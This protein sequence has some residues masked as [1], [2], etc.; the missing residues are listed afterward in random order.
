MLT[1]AGMKGISVQKIARHVFN[2]SN[3]FFETV[4]FEEVRSYVQQYLLKNSK[5]PDSIIES[6]GARGTYRMNP[7]SKESQ[8]LMLL[9]RD[10]KQDEPGS[11]AGRPVAFTLRFLNLPHFPF[12][13]KKS[14]IFWKSFCRFPF[15]LYLCIGKETIYKSIIIWQS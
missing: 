9:F 6:A 15:S 1:E 2:A 13:A 8:Q 10:E 14:R 4:S 7:S 11:Q 12:F 5:N 3:T